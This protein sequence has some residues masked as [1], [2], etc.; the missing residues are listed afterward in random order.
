MTKVLTKNLMNDFMKDI[1]KTLGN[2]R[3]R[4]ITLSLLFILSGIGASVLLNPA[5][6][7]AV[8]NT[9]APSAAAPF[10]AVPQ[11]QANWEYPGG[12]AYNQDYNPQNQ[13]NASNVQYLGLAWLFPMPGLPSG[14]AGYAGGI[15]LGLGTDIAP[16][17]V[18]GTAYVISQA[19][20]VW[21]LNAAN[22]DIIW[23]YVWPIALNVTAG[24]GSILLLHHHDGNAWF[25]TATFGSGVSGPTLW[26][27]S[28]DS[29]HVVALNALTGKEEFNFTDFSGFN[30]AG[31]GIVGNSPSSFY[32]AQGASNLVIDSAKGI[33]IT[34]RDGEVSAG[35]G[36]GFFAGW[37]INVNP[38][39]LMWIAYTTPPQPNS[40]IGLDPSWTVSQINNMS[41]AETMFP[42]KG[43]PNGYVSTTELQGGVMMNVND[44]IVVNWKS[45]TPAQL[46][47]SLYNDWGQVGQSAQCKA[48]T[49]GGST[50]STGSGWGGAW[51]LGSGPTSG[52]VYVSTNNKDPF[53]GPCTPGPD[54]WSA[55]VLALNMTSGQWI[56]GV[57]TTP[58]DLWD[59]D[60][61]WWQAAANETINGVNT[62]VVLKTC[63]NGFLYE[64]NALTG[65]VIWAW[66][67]PTNIEPR[68]YECWDFNPTNATQMSFDFP[69]AIHT[70]KTQPTTGPQPPYLQYPNAGAGFEDVQA[71]DPA[72]N[73][74]FAANE[75]TPNF[76]TYFGLNA[77]LYAPNAA[78]PLYF[79]AFGFSSTPIN[80]GT[81]SDCGPSNDNTTIWGI[82]AATG[83]VV[84]HHFIPLLGY[85]G[86]V[87]TSGGLVFV[88]LASGDMQILNAANGN[89]IRD[90]FVGGPLTELTSVGAAANGQMMLITPINAGLGSSSPGDVLALTLNVPVGPAAST[91]TVTSTATT[92]TTATST[93]TAVSTT[94]TLS[95]TTTTALSTTTSVSTSSTGVSSTALYGV[96]AVAVIFIIATGY[97]AMRGRKPTS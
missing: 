60:C 81:C 50:G 22:G 65:D 68:C 78:S 56:W 61:S 76:D 51:L 26:F 86:G 95:T 69:S 67:P 43:S 66:V 3:I 11:S 30:G 72:T 85:R 17:I 28:T 29:V 70:F 79:F 18:N 44:N 35:N 13:I 53:S 1:K 77:S 8:P 97:L 59:Y 16:I 42:G 96:A 14:L 74:I 24:T 92:T 7:S 31:I 84:W 91:T 21:A 4:A 34:G 6:A 23:S 71:Y 15:F 32:S 73:M 48:I 20:Q 37:N 62:P 90:F 58:H 38:A 9:A 45:L 36:R 46:N 12:N 52:I 94:T 57:Q 25:T 33:A 27:Q 83:G 2:T 5:S 54:L 19:D 75:L 88:T 55:S 10:A 89:L 64:I 47:A 82:N 80:T 93:T 39:K 40:N 63:K 49:G 87:S 41:S